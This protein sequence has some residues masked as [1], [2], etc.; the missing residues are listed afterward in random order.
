LY[1]SSFASFTETGNEETLNQLAYPILDDEECIDLWNEWYLPETEICAG[2]H[3]AG[4][5]F[6]GVC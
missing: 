1:H 3:N 2:Y 4:K 5:D 6:C